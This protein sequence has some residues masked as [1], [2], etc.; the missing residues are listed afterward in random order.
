MN[1]LVTEDVLHSFRMN[2]ICSNNEIGLQDLAIFGRDLAILGVL[3]HV[4]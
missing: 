2:T 4:C 1:N 3:V